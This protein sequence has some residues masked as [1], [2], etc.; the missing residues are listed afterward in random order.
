MSAA[1]FPMTAFFVVMLMAS[2]DSRDGRLWRQMTVSSCGLHFAAQ[3]RLKMLSYS[4]SQNAAWGAKS[5][6]LQ[7][8]APVIR[9]Y[10]A[11]LNKVI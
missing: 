2:T 10:L 6:I 8:R 7:D 3:I 11:W 4:I 5:Q 9:P 1:S